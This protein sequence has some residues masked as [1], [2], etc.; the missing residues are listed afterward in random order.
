MK[1]NP[2]QPLLDMKTTQNQAFKKK[3]SEQIK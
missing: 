2:E 3:G 1:N